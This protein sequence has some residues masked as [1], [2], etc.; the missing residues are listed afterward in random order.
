[1][2][3]IMP[4]KDWIEKII[5]EGGKKYTDCG[6]GKIDDNSFELKPENVMSIETILREVSTK[7]ES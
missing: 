4:Q 3:N 1:M 5:R 2:L 6:E 7:N